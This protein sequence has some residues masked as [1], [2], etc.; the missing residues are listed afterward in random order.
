[1]KE[2]DFLLVLEAVLEHRSITRA[3]KALGTTQSALS[4]ALVRLRARFHDP[5]FV[6]SGA[7]MLPT[8]FVLHLKNPLRRSMQ[9]IREEILNPSRFDPNTTTRV[10]KLCVNEIGALLQAP[11]V[12]RLLRRR[13]KHASIAPVEIPREDV[14]AALESGHADLAIG[15]YPELRGTLYQQALFR[16]SYVAIVRENHPFIKAS[17]TPN[18]F[19]KTPIIRCSATVAVG[20][21]LD[22]IY[23]KAGVRQI[24][25]IETPFVMSLATLA[26]ATDALAFVPEELIDKLKRFASVRVV[27]FPFALPTLAIKQHWHSRLK[28]DEA[29]RFLRQVVHDALHE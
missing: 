16:R 15:H 13:A 26:E 23:S 25:E 19:Y 5:L 10:F 14:G 27:K 6:R 29:H 3:A 21:W 4:H 11:K 24:T 18:Q 20:S 28:N 2:L 1:M 12:I 22:G 9:I 8:P 17:V 7:L